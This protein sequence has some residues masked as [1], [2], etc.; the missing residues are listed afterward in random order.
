[1]AKVY[2][3]DTANQERMM[4]PFVHEIDEGTPDGSVVLPGNN[5]NYY[6]R[7]YVTLRTYPINLLSIL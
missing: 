1:M 5:S 4:M 7:R 2:L 3:D 6:A